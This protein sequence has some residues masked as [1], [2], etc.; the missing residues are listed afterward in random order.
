MANDAEKYKPVSVYVPWELWS[1][2]EAFHA[3]EG[4][5]EISDN[6]KIVS[7]L[8]RWYNTRMEENRKR[9]AAGISR[10]DNPQAARRKV[11]GHSS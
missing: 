3:A 11:P 4:N 10:R 6:K 7:I 2:I 5:P 1:E 8:N 9:G